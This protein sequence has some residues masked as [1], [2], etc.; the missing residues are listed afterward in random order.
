MYSQ[1]QIKFE[2]IYFIVLV[3]FPFPFMVIVEKYVI[4]QGNLLKRRD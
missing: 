4:Y 1:I 2:K 3:I